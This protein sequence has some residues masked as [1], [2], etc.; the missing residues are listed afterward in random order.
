[1]QYAPGIFEGIRGFESSN[2]VFIFRL[3]DHIDRFF[4]SM[5]IYG[6]TP[7]F[8]KEQISDAVKEV[9]E[10]NLLGNCYIRPFS[11]VLDDHIG[12][13]RLNKP[14]STYIAAVP[15]EGYLDQRDPLS[16][17]ISSWRR[18]NSNSM[19]VQDKSS[20]NY[21][22]SVLA[23]SEARTLGFDEAILLDYEGNVAEGPGENVF[24]IKRGELFTPSV[25][26]DILEGITRD[27]V[28]EIASDSGITVSER[29]IHRE[30]LLTADELFFCG[31]AAGISPIGRVDNSIIGN[32]TVRE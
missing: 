19:R 9:V 24:T 30:E 25:G 1:M 14:I 27:S 21:A 8:T 16:V 12:L 11:F 3:R 6:M 28:L 22:N 23:N 2:S 15:F 18:I 10:V 7:Q 29:T 5:K 20:S 4:R 32:G 26:E 17:K 13:S 31:T